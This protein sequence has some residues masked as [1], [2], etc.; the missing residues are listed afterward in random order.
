MTSR[1]RTLNFCL[2]ALG[3]NIGLLILY[4]VAL[5]GQLT[6]NCIES[7]TAANQITR[8]LPRG[9][10]NTLFQDDSILPQ[11]SSVSKSA[12]AIK[13][14]SRETSSY[15]PHSY[16]S[17]Q[18][19]NSIL[20]DIGFVK[21]P[22]RCDG[23]E[24]ISIIV[25]SS[26]SGSSVR[27]AIRDT[28]GKQKK[29]GDT[30]IALNFLL[31]HTFDTV[32]QEQIDTESRVYGDIIQATFEDSYKNLTLKTLTALKWSLTFCQNARYIL[33]VTDD[34]LL[35]PNKIITLAESLR[36]KR[37]F[38]GCPVRVLSHRIVYRSG[39]SAIQT[40]VDWNSA[41]WPQYVSGFMI[42]F[43]KDVARDMYTIACRTPLT[44]PDDGYLGILAEMLGIAPLGYRHHC[45]KP[46]AT[47]TDFKQFKLREIHKRLLKNKHSP[48]L[49]IH[50]GGS[51]ITADV[52]RASW[53]E[54]QIGQNDEDTNYQVF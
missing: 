40:D 49:M 28:W 15:I 51:S 1:H 38:F 23:D 30:K 29:Y 19:T 22:A 18:W 31:A 8:F 12:V 39:K 21:S 41:F 48:T 11:C 14:K 4:Q 26:P 47:I 44:W 53:E 54:I 36:T 32:F 13:L 46:P 3:L 34:I 27:S 6:N 45:V 7:H 5:Y 20:D 2:C 16:W 9:L 52:I 25:L 10:K 17:A 42:L 43:S 24:F 37:I 35:L 50:F 33:R